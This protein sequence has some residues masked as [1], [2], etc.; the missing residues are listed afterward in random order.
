MIGEISREPKKDEYSILAAQILRSK[1][2]SI[3]RLSQRSIDG[4][5]GERTK[6]SSEREG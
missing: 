5:D 4:K 3:G 6:I 2:S 1:K